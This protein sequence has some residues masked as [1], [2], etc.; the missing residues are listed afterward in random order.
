MS[1]E[2]K[3]ELKI[4]DKEKD[5]IKLYKMKGYYNWEIK[6]FHPEKAEKVFKRI[7]EL[8]QKLHDQFDEIEE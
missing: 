1:E 2:I 8:D 5:Y 6:M 4:P 7:V 3:E